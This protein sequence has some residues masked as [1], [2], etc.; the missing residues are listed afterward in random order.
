RARAVADAP[1]PRAAPVRE[2]G[3]GLVAHLVGGGRRSPEPHIPGPARPGQ[4]PALL[5]SEGDRVP[6]RPRR[7]LRRRVRRHRQVV[8]GLSGVARARA[9]GAGPGQPAPPAVSAARLQARCVRLPHGA[10]K[11]GPPRAYSMIS[12]ACS[13]SVWGILNPSAFA[14]LRLITSP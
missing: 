5:A 6:P 8:R 11:P 1:G 10:V 9:P 3:P 2:R 13:R 14:V 12:L 7:S 4:R